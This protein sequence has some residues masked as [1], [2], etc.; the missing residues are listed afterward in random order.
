MYIHG[1]DA[2][3]FLYL[4][5]KGDCIM[6]WLLLISG[7]LFYWFEPITFRSLLKQRN[8][9]KFFPECKHMKSRLLVYWIAWF[10]RVQSKSETKL[11]KLCLEIKIK[12]RL[13]LEFLDIWILVLIGSNHEPVSS[14]FYYGLWSQVGCKWVELS[15]CHFQLELD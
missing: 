7:W 4:W 8:C 2:V 10:Y 3:L 11:N 1:Q 14:I 6:L 12:L 9:L 15:S 5:S 13:C